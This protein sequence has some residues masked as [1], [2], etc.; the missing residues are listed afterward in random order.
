M[1]NTWVKVV[2]LADCIFEKWDKDHECPICPI[3]KK[4]YAECKHP[5]PHME[6]EYE[7]KIVED[8]LW[9]RKR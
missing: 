1:A 8:V 5:G 3:C 2:M 7:Y 6:E 9:A 4:D